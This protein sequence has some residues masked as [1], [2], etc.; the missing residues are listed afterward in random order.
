MRRLLG[1]LESRFQVA[2][3]TDL[4]DRVG[5]RLQKVL[6]RLDHP[7][8]LDSHPLAMPAARSVGMTGERRRPAQDNG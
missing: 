4:V 6:L 3:G 7:R 1:R 8:I 5:E 2:F